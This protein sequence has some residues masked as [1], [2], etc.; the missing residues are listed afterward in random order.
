[1][2][3]IDDQSVDRSSRIVPHAST[4]AGTPKA[5]VERLRQGSQARTTAKTCLSMPSLSL[6][7]E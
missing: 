3:P 7:E 4:S 2:L 1:M 5:C 6:L